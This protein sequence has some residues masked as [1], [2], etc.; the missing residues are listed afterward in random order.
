[1]KKKLLYI[2]YGIVITIVF[3]YLLFPSEAVKH[4]IVTE[5]ASRNPNVVVVIDDIRLGIPAVL[6]FDDVELRF[7]DK[8]GAVL[9]AK[10]VTAWP[11]LASLLRGKPVVRISTAAYGGNIDATVFSPDRFAIGTSVTVDAEVNQINIGECSYLKKVLGRNFA[12]ILKGTLTFEGRY[13][14]AITGAGTANFIAQNGNVELLKSIV[15]ISTLTFDEIT[16]AMTLKNRTLKIDGVDFTGNEARGS[17][18][19]SVLLQRDIIRSRLSLRG[20][21][22]IPAVNKTF[23]AFV[24]GTL[25]NPIPRLR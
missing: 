17:L 24:S 12:G 3:L 6:E 8:P 9:E 18:N 19:G 21:V 15:G 4:Y 11:Q 14:D 16:A 1:M 22:E 7:K 23:S 10:T 13:D 2:T 5:V 25:G 20:T